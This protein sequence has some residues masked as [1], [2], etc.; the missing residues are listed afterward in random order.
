MK[1]A[2][3]KV[4]AYLR[5]YLGEPNLDI[6]PDV[7]LVAMLNAIDRDEFVDFLDGFSRRFKIETPRIVDAKAYLGVLWKARGPKLLDVSR[8]ATR[9]PEIRVEDITL[10]E[11]AEIS[12]SGKW[13]LRHVFPEAS[14]VGYPS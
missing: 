11:L 7:S 6:D 13:P 3:Q 2:E 9:I 14:G 1:P 10:R 8:M 5:E 12:E 4:L